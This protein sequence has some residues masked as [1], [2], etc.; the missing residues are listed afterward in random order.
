MSGLRRRVAVAM[1]GALFTMAG[2]TAASAQVFGTF[3]WQMQPYCNTITLTLTSVTGNFTLDG[4]DDQCG[5]TK[6]GSATGIGVFN[7][8][9]TVSLNF[10]IVSAPSGSAVHVSASVNPA[11]GQGTWT[12]SRGRNGTFAF[13][14]TTPGLPPLT[15]GDVRFRIGGLTGTIPV[16][17]GSSEDV[18][19]WETTAYNIGGGVYAPATG[20]YTVPVSGTYLITATVQWAAFAAATGRQCLRIDA[21]ALTII[22][23]TCDTPSTDPATVPHVSTVA[24]LNA[25][26]GVRIRVF[27][28]SG[29]AVNLG[30]SSSS[31]SVFTV[32]LLQ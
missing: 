18:N 19:T 32:T 14:G 29:A 9:G 16:A 30:P 12:D 7:P 26:T 5:A 22:G 31:G 15:V 20:T 21:P 3:S 2:A 11:N 17:S 8:D 6:K 24:F 25:G 23:V 10:T 28:T 4:S 1:T 13:F 27:Q